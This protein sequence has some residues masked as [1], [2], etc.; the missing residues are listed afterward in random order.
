MS[1]THVLTPIKVG[2]I[3]LR[4]RVARTAHGTRLA[5][6]SFEDLTAFHAL[7]AEGGVGLAILEI[8]GV[9]PTSPMSL[10]VFNSAHGEGLSRMME[11]LKPLG[12][13]VFQLIWHGGHHTL[14]VDG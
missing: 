12:M 7:R 9:H 8:M 4:N 14:P 13:K 6:H 3:E 1:L 10:N 2:P 5:L 11:K